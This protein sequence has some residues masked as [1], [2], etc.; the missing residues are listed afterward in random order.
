MITEQ[1]SWI[2]GYRL[3]W[4]II[5]FDLP[6]VEKTDRRAATKFRNYLLDEG[7]SMG[8]YSIYYRLLHGKESVE[9]LKRR[10][11]HNLPVHG[12][13]QV[14]V[15][16]DKQYESIQTFRSRREESQKKAEQFLLF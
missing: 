9:S 1:E 10:I 8:Q 11:S 4:A 12:V 14:L 7:F 6:V 13:I 15:I 16:T 3:M 5:M 2:S